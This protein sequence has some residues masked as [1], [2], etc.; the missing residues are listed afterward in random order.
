MASETITIEA[1]DGEGTV[2]DS[3]S[4]EIS[5]NETITISTSGNGG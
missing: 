3:L 5:T 1:R 4:I 2:L